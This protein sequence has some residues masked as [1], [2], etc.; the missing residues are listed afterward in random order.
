[1]SNLSQ[2]LGGSIPKVSYFTSSGTFTKP[3]NVAWVNALLVGAGSGYTSIGGGGGG[4]VGGLLELG[5]GGQGE[6]EGGERGVTRARDVE[7]LA[8]GGRRGKR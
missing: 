1:M 7:D 2:F 6:H 5:A 8:R 3:S 4:E